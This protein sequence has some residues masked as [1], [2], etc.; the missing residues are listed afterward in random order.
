MWYTDGSFLL[1]EGVCKAG[2]GIV[3]TRAVEAW[4]LPDHNTDQ[5]AELIALTRAC[6]FPKGQFLN[7]YTD[8]KYAFIFSCHMQLSGEN[9]AFNNKRRT[10]T[11]SDQIIALLEASHLP[12]L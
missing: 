4:A 5:Q 3:S 2:Y 6:Q 10:M 1:H 12:Q 9:G 11:N 7:L 8:P